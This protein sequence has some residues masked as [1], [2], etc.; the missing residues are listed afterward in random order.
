MRV[1]AEEPMPRVS[2]INPSIPIIYSRDFR[3]HFHA[4]LEVPI[5]DFDFFLYQ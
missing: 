5:A 3:L 2:L 1:G 4:S